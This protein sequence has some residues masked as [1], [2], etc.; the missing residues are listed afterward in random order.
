MLKQQGV[1]YTSSLGKHLAAIR[2]N[3]DFSLRRVEELTNYTVSNAYLSQIENG[4]IRHPS[5]N[6]LHALSEVYNTSY[7]QLMLAAGYITKEEHRNNFHAGHTS[8]LS[9]LNVS[10]AEEMELVK[11][12]EFR[13]NMGTK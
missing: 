2:S 4:K 13:R 12:L 9:S 5:P 6:I 8:T 1:N 7:E 3:R 10:Q 11:Y